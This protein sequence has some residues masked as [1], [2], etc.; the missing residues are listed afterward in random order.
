[1]LRVSSLS[2]KKVLDVFNKLFLAFCLQLFENAFFKKK[3]TLLQ[4]DT[5]YSEAVIQ[6]FLSNADEKSSV[7]LLRSE[8]EK[9]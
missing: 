3:K 5:M 2:L 1:M 7:V 9:S 4:C 8:M 6:G